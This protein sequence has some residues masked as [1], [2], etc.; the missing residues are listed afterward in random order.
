MFAGQQ[1]DI[2]GGILQ[3]SVVRVVA[4][5]ARHVADAFLSLAYGDSTSEEVVVP[6]VE[7]NKIWYMK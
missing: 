4:D 1:R 6:M 2:H 7:R 5:T 3:V